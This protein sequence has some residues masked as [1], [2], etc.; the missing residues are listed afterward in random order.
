MQYTG[1]SFSKTLAKL[2]ASITSEQKTYSEIETN[3]V[4][5][6]GRSYQSNYAEFFEKNI[7]DKVSNQ[8]LH[9]MN[10]FSFIHNGQV[11]MYILYGFIFVMLLIMA[12]FF[13]VL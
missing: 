3:D 1:K 7:I 9:F 6:K 13:N 10:H 4:F 11:Q 12:T 5:P 2:F 8:L